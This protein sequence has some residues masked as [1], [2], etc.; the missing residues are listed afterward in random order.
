MGKIVERG[1]LSGLIG[2]LRKH[3]KTIVTMN[4]SFDL[5]HA[6]HVRCL[7]EA[8]TQGDVLIVPLNSDKSVQ[9]YKGRERPIVHQ[10]DRAEMLA[11]LSCVDYVVLFD[12][13]NPKAILAE[14]RPDVHCNGA[15]WGP[16]C[17]ERE[18]VEQNEGRL[19]ILKWSPGRSTTE[20]LARIRSAAKSPGAVIVSGSILAER[21]EDVAAQAALLSRLASRE[22]KLILFSKE[23]SD[24]ARRAFGDK[25]VVFDRAYLCPL[26]QA[27]QEARDEM[28]LALSSSWVV[29]DEMHHIIAGRELNAKTLLIGRAPK[30]YVMPHHEADDLEQ[31]VSIILEAVS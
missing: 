17:I 6:G 10:E 20:I 26:I 21:Q 23:P 8:K 19:H 16:G 4:G 24:T 1:E 18:V 5:L 27:L 3:G 31:A 25:G 11:A 30:G 15:D 13:T 2:S 12:D 7:Q 28:G 14:I 9:S 29:S 22:S